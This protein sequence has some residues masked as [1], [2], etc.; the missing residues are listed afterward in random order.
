MYAHIMNWTHKDSTQGASGPPTLC[1]RLCARPSY[2]SHLSPTSLQRHHACQ[3]WLPARTHFVEQEYRH[4]IRMHLQELELGVRTQK[5]QEWDTWGPDKAGG[6]DLHR[7]TTMTPELDI[8]DSNSEQSIDPWCK[9]S[10][11]VVLDV[12]NEQRGRGGCGQSQRKAPKRPGG[13]DLG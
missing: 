2:V 3:S 6:M 5:I 12:E 9:L 7:P 13:G 10:I 11:F 4:R 1:L 8:V